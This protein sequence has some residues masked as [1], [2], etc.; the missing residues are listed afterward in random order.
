MMTRTILAT[1]LFFA[2]L[3]VGC[4]FGPRA[5]NNSSSR[6]MQEAMLEDDAATEKA[7]PIAELAAT[8]PEEV[9]GYELLVGVL[10]EYWKC[11]EGPGTYKDGA[12]TRVE[13][14]HR[15]TYASMSVL[16]VP[17]ERVRSPKA[18]AHAIGMAYALSG[19]EVTPLKSDQSGSYGRFT[20]SGTRDWISIRGALM[21]YRLPNNPGY[22]AKLQGE[23]L[24]NVHE[25][26]LDDFDEFASAVY[27][28]P[29]K[30]ARYELTVE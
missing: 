19:M 5:P 1:T 16:V 17:S 10:P 12:D 30:R 11:K 21:V 6:M 22:T 14:E 23:W 29:R 2:L 13:F 15:G 4:A 18:E 24:P 26:M 7:A 20:Y 28:V 3:A 8:S 27:M 9:I 25:Y